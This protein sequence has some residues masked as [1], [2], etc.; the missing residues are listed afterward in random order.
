M[1]SCYNLI[2]KNIIYMF[3]AMKVHHQVVICNVK[4]RGIML[5]PSVYGT[6]VNHNMCD[7]MD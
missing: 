2:L 7:K 3:W 1:H 4:Q 6:M 5:C